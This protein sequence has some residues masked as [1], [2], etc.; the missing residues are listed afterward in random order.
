MGVTHYT[1]LYKDPVKLASICL[2]S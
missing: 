1:A 2:R